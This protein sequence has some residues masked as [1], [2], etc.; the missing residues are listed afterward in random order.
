MVNIHTV[1][2]A[3]EVK[4]VGSKGSGYYAF[5]HYGN[6]LAY[7]WNE[8][9]ADLFLEHGSTVRKVIKSG[10]DSVPADIKRVPVGAVIS[11]RHR[12]LRPGLPIETASFEHDDEPT[13]LHVAAIPLDPQ[14]RKACGGAISCA[15]FVLDEWEGQKAFKLRGMATDTAYQGLGVGCLVLILGE[16]LLRSEFGEALPFWCNA[17]INAAPFYERFGWERVSD[18]FDIPGVGPHVKMLKKTA[19]V[20]N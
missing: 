18:E 5:D 3:A 1:I 17:R 7:F 2:Q 16:E 14:S 10:W 4:F 9:T 15:T 11:L 19:Q 13:T 20:A 6:K 8:G 12:I